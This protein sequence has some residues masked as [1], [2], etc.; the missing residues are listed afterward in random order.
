M[1]FPAKPGLLTAAVLTPFL[2]CPILW[3]DGITRSVGLSSHAS[4]ILFIAD[5]FQPL[6]G[7]QTQCAPAKTLE[8]HFHPYSPNLLM[9]G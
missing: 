6:A 5:V 1:R 7:L 9:P 8:S 4:Q 2:V 3:P